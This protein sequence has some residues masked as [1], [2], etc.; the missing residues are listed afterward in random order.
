M[1]GMFVRLFA[2][3]LAN[4]HTQELATAADNPDLTSARSG[5]PGAQRRRH[6]SLPVSFSS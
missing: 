1:F 6:T 2:S 4:M 3:E 5:R